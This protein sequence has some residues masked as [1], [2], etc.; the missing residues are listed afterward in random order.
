MEWPVP[1][2]VDTLASSVIKGLEE[3]IVS[4]NSQMHLSDKPAEISEL[5]MEMFLLLRFTSLVLVENLSRLDLRERLQ[6]VRNYLYERLDQVRQSQHQHE[7]DDIDDDDDDDDN[8]DDDDD[9]DNDNDDDDDDELTRQG[10]RPQR[11][12]AG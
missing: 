1:H 6:P 12:P 7:D 2:I 11:P 8:D 10:A 4:R 5:N 9:D 3:S